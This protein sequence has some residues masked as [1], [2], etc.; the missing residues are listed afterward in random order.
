MAKKDRTAKLPR[1]IAGVKVPKAVRK[2]MLGD[3]LGSKAGQALIAQALMA[4]SAAILA[5]QQA[6]PDS[7]T[8]PAGKRAAPFAPDAVAFAFAEAGRAFAEALNA[9]SASLEA[10]DADWPADF[11]AP[12]MPDSAEAEAA[13]TKPH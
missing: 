9:R 4:I 5:K 10:P 7:A 3:F 12:S 6:E 13:A 2:G 11:E 1:R 8:R